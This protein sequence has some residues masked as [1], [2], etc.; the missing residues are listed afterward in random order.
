MSDS[1]DLGKHGEDIASKYLEDKGYKILDRNWTSGKI[2]LD[3]IA[4]NDE[5]VAFVEVKTRS[6]NFK[7]SPADAVTVPKQRSII[8]AADNY[9]RQ[10]R[11]D[12]ECRFDIISVVSKDD[13]YDIDHMEGAFYP[14]L[15]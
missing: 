2:E 9:L 11:I 15:R 5:V 3:I 8:F 4:E 12:K 1:Y 7:L 6:D 14:T 10:K 13:N